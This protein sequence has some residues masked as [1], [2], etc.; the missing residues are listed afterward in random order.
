M[1]ILS[2]KVEALYIRK[3]KLGKEHYH[4]RIKT[5]V[6][7][8]CDNCQNIFSR[9]L[10]QTDRKRLNNDVYHVC[11]DCDQKRFAQK[12]GAERRRLWNLPIDSDLDITKI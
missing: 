5:L 1:F 4:K 10:G 3:S 12:K 9:L 2:K 6:V 11:P 8:S 7:F